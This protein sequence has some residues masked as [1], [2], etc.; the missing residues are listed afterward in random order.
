MSKNYLNQKLNKLMNETLEYVIYSNN[1][2]VSPLT[3][4]SLRNC[5]IQD[6]VYSYR[7]IK[8]KLEN[9]NFWYNYKQSAKFRLDRTVEI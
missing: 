5:I 3:T 2:L 7:Y 1:Y 6:F 4:I 8:E 9:F